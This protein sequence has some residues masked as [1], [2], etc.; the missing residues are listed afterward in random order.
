MKITKGCAGYVDK[1]KK[2][3]ITMAVI[4]FGIVIAIFILGYVQTKTRLN[5]LT[6]VAILG[7]LPASKA[8]VGV[9]TI[10]PYKSVPNKVRREI[11]V[12]G[13]LLTSVFDTVITSYE[14][15]LPVDC[16]VI[17][18]NIVC[19]YTHHKKVDAEYAAKHIKAMLEQ[20]GYEK[21]TVKIF[22]DYAKFMARVEGLNSMRKVDHEQNQRKEEGIKRVLLNISM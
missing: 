18:D 7:C 22:Q 15:V 10:F 13:H 21:V 8:L 3:L 6:V 2:Q 11:D 12:K 20:N 9:I 14:K 1:R 17:S 4:E 16:F 19:G 5:L